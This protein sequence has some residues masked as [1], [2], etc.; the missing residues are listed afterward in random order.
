MESLHLTGP[1]PAIRRLVQLASGIGVTFEVEGGVLRVP[2]DESGALI[3]AAQTV[4]APLE[5]GLVKAIRT[6][7]SSGT[8]LSLL[9]VA[10]ASP[11]LANL[12]ARRKHRRLLHAIH[13][14]EG[15]TMG[16]QPVVELATGR[17]AGFEALL[18]VRVGTTDITPADVLSAAEDCGRLVEVDA[19]A[20]SV[21]VQE[22]AP[23]IGHRMLFV[24]LLPASLPVPEEQ[25]APFV[26]EVD[27]LG[28]DPQ[29]IVL[30]APVGPAGTLRRQLES[31]FG[32]ARDAGFSI[33][34]DNVRSQRDLDAIDVVPDFV[35]L[36]RTMVRSVA[37]PSGTRAIGSVVRDAAYSEAVVVA[38]GIE[39]ADQLHAVRDLGVRYAQGWELGRPG[40]IPAEVG[41][42]H[43]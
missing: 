19:V 27:E 7:L 28:L 23:A 3:D 2:F 41:A 9:T 40:A 38:Q 37:S 26:K 14:R 43:A 25:L 4:L 34:L 21:A 6:D 12:A 11:S 18:R 8:S 24:N 29:N 32:A 33:G 16:Y 31:V 17:I 10:C 35:K 36:D 42:Q 39:S 1:P 5:A 20:R 13:A 30:E 22:A 15:V